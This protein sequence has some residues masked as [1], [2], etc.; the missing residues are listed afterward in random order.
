MPTS[1]TR[2]HPSCPPARPALGRPSTPV[3]ASTLRWRSA[4]VATL[5]A[6]ATTL[7]TRAHFPFLI[8]D[9][10]GATAALI[11]SETLEP[12]GEVSLGLLASGTYEIIDRSGR[13]LPLAAPSKDTTA[14]SHP[15][16][17]PGSGPRLIVGEVDLGIMQRGNGPAH[18]LVY[19]PKTIVGD[20][21]AA[22]AVKSEPRTVELLPV[23][24]AAPADASSAAASPMALELRVEGKPLPNAPLMLVTER[25]EE[26]EIM[27]DASGRTEPLPPGRYAAWARHWIDATGEVDG[28]PY[29]Q[30]RRYATLVVDLPGDATAPASLSETAPA[31]VAVS[32]LPRP[33]ASFGATIADGWLYVYGGHT[34]ERHDYSTATVSGRFSRI[35]LDSLDGRWEELPGGPSVQ[36]MNLVSHRGRIIRVG[37]MEPRNAPGQPTDNHSLVEVASF[38]PTRGIW[39]A[40]APLPESRSSHDVVVIGDTLFVVGGWSLAGAGSEPIWLDHA[41][42]L[43][44]ARDGAAWERIEQ[45]FRRRALIAAALG[46]DLVVMGGFDEFDRPHVEALALDTTTRTWRPLPPLPGSPAN[47]FAPAACVLDGRLYASVTDGALLRLA[48]DRGSWER[49]AVTTPRHVHRLVAHAGEVLLIGGARGPTMTDLVEAV[50]ITAEPRRP[51]V[52][53]AVAKR[54]THPETEK[55]AAAMGMV[56]EAVDALRFA[57]SGGWN[58]DR[59]QLRE[60]ADRLITHLREVRIDGIDAP[61]RFRTLLAEN[62]ERGEILRSMLASGSADAAAL[63]RQLALIRASCRD[64]HRDYRD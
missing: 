15:V 45:P 2:S 8:P 40:L 26:R 59:N 1:Q 31:G 23:R 44:L 17:L 30:V 13:R 35:R 63:T 9:R 49:V 53:A 62:L 21:F 4:F 47:G 39:T 11:M 34:G 61:E 6:A 43:D 38:D 19:F 41:L 18:R 37:G 7:S 28:K 10:S 25:G 57:E 24:L 5:A 3:V 64:C 54:W 29:T 22:D 51:S 58:G 32:T 56:D 20:P 12:D 55:V 14:D 48:D 60:E 27:T 16:A 50:A 36:G 46:T 52:L 33:V 42:A